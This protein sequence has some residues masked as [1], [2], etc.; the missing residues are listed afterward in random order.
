MVPELLLEMRSKRRVVTSGKSKKKK[1]KRHGKAPAGLV[2]ILA[3]SDP[4]F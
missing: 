2:Y 1:K 4:E 3:D